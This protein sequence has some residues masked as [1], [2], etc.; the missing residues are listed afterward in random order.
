M[1]SNVLSAL[2]G[3]LKKKKKERKE[4]RFWSRKADLLSFLSLNATSGGKL[5]QQLLLS[6]GYLYLISFLLNKKLKSTC[7]WK[8]QE[9]VSLQQHLLHF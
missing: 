2:S 4:K 3:A 6:S 5:A 7:K 1:A 8:N 9:Y